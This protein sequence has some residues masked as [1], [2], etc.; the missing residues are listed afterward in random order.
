MKK[1]KKFLFC[2]S[3]AA[4]TSCGNN[5]STTTETEKDS[6]ATTKAANPVAEVAVNPLKDCYFGDLHLHTSLSADANFL[7]TNTLPED[8][9]KY[10]MGEEVVYMGQKV[11]RN[12][13]LD[14]LAVTDHAEYLGVIAAIRDPNGAYAGSAL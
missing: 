9:Y 1:F 5:S 11:K 3:A 8:A 2:I 6:T 13:P 7:G 10:A 12:A 4:L 14:F